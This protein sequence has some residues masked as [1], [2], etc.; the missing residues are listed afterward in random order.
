MPQTLLAIAAMMVATL[1]AF[2]QQRNVME[3]RMQM[4]RSEVV[5]NATGVAVDR[6]EEIGV[7]AFDDA[8]KGEDK[9]FATSSLTSMLTFTDDAP[10]VDDVDDFDGSI[11]ERFRVYG[12]DT[13]WYGVETRV[14]YASEA[15]PDAEIVDP[16]QRTKMKKATVTVYSLNIPNIDTIRISQSYT[17]GSKCDW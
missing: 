5:T 10:P 12:A 3:T 4:V 17:C 14:R 9:I 16:S 15:Q 6:L 7:M 1:F 11:V 13:L 8:T 2:Q